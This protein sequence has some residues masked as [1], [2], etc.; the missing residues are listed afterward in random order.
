VIERGE[1][2]SGRNPN[3]EQSKEKTAGTPEL[4]IF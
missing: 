1:G 4:Y 3:E 2:G